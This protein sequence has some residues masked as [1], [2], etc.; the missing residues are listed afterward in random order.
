MANEGSN[1]RAPGEVRDAVLATLEAHPAGASV[2]QIIDGTR[3]IIGD[4]P[5][6]ERSILPAP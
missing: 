1:R 5:G 4:V 3:S 2:T 6:V